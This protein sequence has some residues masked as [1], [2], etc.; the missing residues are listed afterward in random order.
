MSSTVNHP[1]LQLLHLILNLCTW[2][3]KTYCWPSQ[4]KL[5]ALL[6]LRHG[7]RMSVRTLN[8]HLRALEE[9]LWLRRRRR[10]RYDAKHGFTFRSSLYIPCHRAMQRVVRGAWQAARLIKT[11]LESRPSIRVTK[12]AEQLKTSL[13]L[14]VP[15]PKKQAT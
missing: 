1:N 7:I 9:Q 15:S 3:G 6:W 2:S 13:G 8:R 14:A 5:V 10:H 4:A 11:A 12:M